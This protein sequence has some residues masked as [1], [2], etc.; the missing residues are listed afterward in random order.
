MSKSLTADEHHPVIRVLDDGMVLAVSE[1]SYGDWTFHIAESLHWKLQTY[2]DGWVYPSKRK[3]VSALMKWVEGDT[4]PED[5]WIRHFKSGRRRR[6]GDPDQ[7]Y[8]ND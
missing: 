7:E 6:G 5:G 1:R 4:E 8:Y 3:A 2:D